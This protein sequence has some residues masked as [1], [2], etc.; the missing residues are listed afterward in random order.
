MVNLKLLKLA[1]GVPRLQHQLLKLI[2][3][4]IAAE[5]ESL[6]LLANRGAEVRLKKNRILSPKEREV[7]AYHEMRH[8]LVALALG[9]ARTPHGAGE[10]ARCTVADP[11]FSGRRGD[12]A[13]ADPAAW[14]GRAR[15]LRGQPR[16]ARSPDPWP[17]ALDARRAGA[18]ASLGHRKPRRS[19]A[20]RRSARAARASP[21]HSLTRCPG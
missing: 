17:G 16:G 7:V 20:G 10:I 19:R 2:G 15:C 12:L 9:R 5:H 1:G 11:G 21:A 13:C 6:L 8:A 3:K 14:G 18:D 4:E